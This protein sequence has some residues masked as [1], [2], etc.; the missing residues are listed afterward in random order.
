MDE[1]G[2]G[3]RRLKRAR[4]HSFFV[5]VTITGLHDSH[6]GYQLDMIRSFIAVLRL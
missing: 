1:G 2:T 6:H 3:M 4:P 5:P